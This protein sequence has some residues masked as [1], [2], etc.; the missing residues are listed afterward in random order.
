MKMA[1]IVSDCAA[2]VH[3]GGEVERRFRAFDIPDE[4]A[5]YIRSVRGMYT[6]VSLAVIDE[7]V[8]P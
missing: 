4:I 8:T 1:V 5:E 7:E 6:T 3:V 2:A